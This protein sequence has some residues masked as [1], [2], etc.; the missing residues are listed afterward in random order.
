M[1]LVYQIQAKVFFSPVM[2]DCELWLSL[3]LA[4]FVIY[5]IAV[6]I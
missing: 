5:L 2:L 6:F 4:T 1:W 3:H